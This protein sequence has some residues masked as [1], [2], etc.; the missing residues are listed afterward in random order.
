MTKWLGLLLCCATLLRAEILDRIA[1]I[2]NKQVITEAQI[3]EEL[4]VTAFQNQKPVMQ[5]RSGRR[6][7]A[8]R[9]IQQALIGQEMKISKYPL[10]SSQEIETFFKE[11]QKNFDSESKFKK[12]LSDYRLTVEILRDHLTRQLM[13]MRFIEYRFEPEVEISDEEIASYYQQHIETQKGEAKSVPSLE[14][15]KE[16]IQ[17]IL[18]QEKINL[19][20]DHWIGEERRQTEIVYLDST[21]Q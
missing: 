20:L 4:R 1:I 14:S 3:D 21:L 9:L 8:D 15:S 7:A 12:S 2:A 5:N 13:T 16:N 18:T 19:A 17:E 10:P 11:T 6:E